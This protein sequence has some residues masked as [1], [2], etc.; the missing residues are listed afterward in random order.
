M[1]GEDLRARLRRPAIRMQIGGFRPPDAPGGSWFGR[2]DLALPGEAWP[3]T[4]GLPML[5][6]C[7]I[8]LA[9]L[10][11]RPPRL[12]DLAMI[13]VFVGP[14]ELPDDTPNGDAW[15]LRAYPELSR[16]VPLAAPARSPIR[17]FPMRPEAIEDDFPAWDDL[18]GDVGEMDD[19]GY[20]DRFPNQDGLKLGG[21]PTL[22]QGEISW[23]AADAH[24]GP[25]YVFQVD[26]VEKAGW[27]WGDGG[28]GYFGRGTAPGRTGEWALSWQC[29]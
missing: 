11:Y 19:E 6:L 2:V 25:E 7:Q 22:V 3:T 27:T 23:P 24:A 29:Y 9:E 14:V 1:N 26:T 12:E 13:A 18:P 10:P 28:V 5:P 20:E 4:G 21:W 8:N 15:C 16:L 17:A